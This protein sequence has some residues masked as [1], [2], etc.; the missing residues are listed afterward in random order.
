METIE[1][2]VKLLIWLSNRLVISATQGEKLDDLI[3]NS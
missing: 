3:V 1:I 2:H